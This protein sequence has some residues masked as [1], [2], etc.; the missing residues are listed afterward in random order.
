[1]LDLPPWVTEE[2]KSIDIAEARRVLENNHNGLEKV[3]ERIIQ[4]LAVMKLKQENRARSFSLRD[5]RGG[6]VKPVWERVLQM[7]LEGSM[8]G[9]ASAVLKMKPKSEATGGHMLELSPPEGLSRE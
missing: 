4:H 7:P 9:P 5:L 8:S 3:K 6:P 1:M 2:K